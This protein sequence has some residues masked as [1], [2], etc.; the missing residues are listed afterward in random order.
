M[1]CY[2]YVC[3]H[4]KFSLKFRHFDIDMDDDQATSIDDIRLWTVPRLRDFLR[5]RKLK[6]SGRK[7][8]LVA[9]VWSVHQ[10][11]ELAP[12]RLRCRGLR[13]PAREGTWDWVRYERWYFVQIRK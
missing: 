5:K 10:S 12:V 7:D 3:D 6:V 1:F 8:E 9:L 11:P 13:Q 4:D 2:V